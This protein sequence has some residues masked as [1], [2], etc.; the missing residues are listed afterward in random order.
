MSRMATGMLKILA[1][2]P[3][4]GSTLL[5]LEG[6]IMGPWVEEVKIASEAALGRGRLSLDLADVSFVDRRGIELLWSLRTRGVPLNGC[7]S[8][9][10][11]QLKAG[12]RS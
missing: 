7:T 5:R 2:E 9:V 12:V 10:L 8:F 3:E 4:T 1:S 11:E 6:Q